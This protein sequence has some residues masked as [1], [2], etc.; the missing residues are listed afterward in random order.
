MV[1]AHARRALLYPVAAVKQSLG[2]LMAGLTIRLTPGTVP[3]VTPYEY[4]SDQFTAMADGVHTYRVRGRAG[5]EEG[6]VVPW[7]GLHARRVDSYVRKVG[8]SDDSRRALKALSRAGKLKATP[9]RSH[10]GG[11]WAC[12]AAEC[13]QER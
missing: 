6:G 1:G 2:S 8:A 5:E 11:P 12:F 9:A 4:T 10:L 13:G 3:R 7:G